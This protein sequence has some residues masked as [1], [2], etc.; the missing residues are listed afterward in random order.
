MQSIN[1]KSNQ[2]LVAVMTKLMIRK[3]GPIGGQFLKILKNKS[4]V[5]IGAMTT[6]WVRIIAS[7]FLSNVNLI[8]IKTFLFSGCA[9]GNGTQI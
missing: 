7:S 9:T 8:K 4:K 5:K 6:N 3:T 1:C 2:T